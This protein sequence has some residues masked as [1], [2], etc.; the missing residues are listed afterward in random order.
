[1]A[2]VMVIGLGGTGI[3][4]LIHVKKM[5][6][7]QRKMDAEGNSQDKIKLL[8]LDTRLVPEYIQGIGGW[9]AS[10]ARRGSMGYDGMVTLETNVDYLPLGGDVYDWVQN[11]P[12]NHFMLHWL[13]KKYFCNNPSADNL[14]NIIDGA[15][16]FRQIGRLALFSELRDGLGSNIY[17]KMDRMVDAMD[18][19]FDLII[20]ASFAGGTGAA[21]F[22][23]IAHL[24]KQIAKE[25]GKN[26]KNAFGLFALPEAF[27]HT[28]NLQ[29]NESMQA[30]SFAAMRELCLRTTISDS[31]L[32][33]EMRYTEGSDNVLA[34]RTEG[35]IFTAV[36]LF[37]KRYQPSSSTSQLNPL[38]VEI[39]Y[40]VA[41][42]MASWISI[43]TDNQAQAPFVGW[44][45][46]RAE[47]IAH[48]S[49][50][51]AYPPVVGGIGT[52]SVVLPIAA[53]VESWTVRLSE[54]IIDMLLPLTENGQA[55]P[56]RRGDKD[57]IQGA[58]Q[59][60]SDWNDKSLARK[61]PAACDMGARGARYKK[62]DARV[63]EEVSNRNLSGWQDV[64]L[65]PED[66]DDDDYKKMGEVYFYH[67]SDRKFVNSEVKP[68]H[69]KERANDAKAAMEDLERDCDQRERELMAEWRSLLSG[70]VDRQ[71]TVYNKHLIELVKSELNGLNNDPEKTRKCG[72][73]GWI[74]DYVKE[75]AE[76]L[77]PGIKLL[78]DSR[79]NKQKVEGE[80]AESMILEKLSAAESNWRKQKDYIAARQQRLE[81][82]RWDLQAEMEQVLIERTQR[83]TVDMEKELKQYVLSLRTHPYG[84]INDDLIRR[85]ENIETARNAGKKMEKVRELINDP[86]WEN[87]EYQKYLTAQAALGDV[88]EQVLKDIEWE[89]EEVT[90]EAGT[91]DAHQS[92]KLN[93]RIHG[94]NLE[95]F[96][97]LNTDLI[98]PIEKDVDD[99]RVVSNTAEANTQRV[100]VRCRKI[101][102]GAWDKLN[103]VDYLTDKWPGAQTN[104]TPEAF[105]QKLLDNCTPVL[106]IPDGNKGTFLAYIMAPTQNNQSAKIWLDRALKKL[107]SGVEIDK[108]D[109]T[110]LPSE[111]KTTLQY[112]SMADI[113]DAPKLTS[114]LDGRRAYMKLSPK[115][116]GVR[117]SRAL[118]HVFRAEQR[119]AEYD[120]EDELVSTRV[121]GILEEDKR[122]ELF[123]Q[124]CAL[125]LIHEESI[126]SK[127][128]T[129]IGN[130]KKLI[131]PP[132]MDETDNVGRLIKKDFEFWLNKPEDY[133]QT[134]VPFLVAAETL[135]L[136]KIDHSENNV[137]MKNALSR[138]ND[139][140][141]DIT[142][143][144]LEIRKKIWAEDPEAMTEG[145]NA[146]QLPASEERNRRLWN[147]LYL[148]LYRRLIDN[149]N[150]Y[151]RELNS[152]EFINKIGSNS[153]FYMLKPDE[154][155]FVKL[156]NKIIQQWVDRI[157]RN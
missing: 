34:A 61:M 119:A 102:D 127:N 29:V 89:V 13:N 11:L 129:P 91:E 95:P 83:F 132:K 71:V 106:N 4:T 154:I 15:S 134:P 105:A 143:K 107:T 109:S 100:I 72:K 21:L 131:L 120:N 149:N 25:K 53:I 157:L 148:D 80:N 77:N 69:P 40:G 84:N 37:D 123:I 96:G 92:P 108:N 115:S 12:D 19:N 117:G 30:R 90:R 137:P 114:Y 54:K 24:V 87:A 36:Y 2:S 56:A 88:H 38:D 22:V 17:T 42:T 23:D 130:V 151:I 110:V 94:F 46:N 7:D 35:S 33:F 146:I 52:Y 31:D 150:D 85:R 138:L 41:P 136:R 66:E 14:L 97:I 6:I 63:L 27:A 64:L 156:M 133:S 74:L 82:K 128:N 32:G 26:A 75:Q 101:F 70:Y 140:I 60:L 124:A 73:L 47:T 44:F 142:E 147:A 58:V 20:C 144:E 104:D 121:T 50:A 79:N 5:L 39:E 9:E 28:P 43:F 152:R 99:R 145:R 126:R 118:N 155:I 45:T 139:Y 93:L 68:I 111:D 76:D 135:C 86:E 81:W 67:P 16:Q 116:I 49:Q 65:Y 8:G 78:K 51:G 122:L 48:K 153:N 18:N 10:L 141:P 55:H 113:I 103:V 98:V 1:M 3:K 59:A 57:S 62:G 112:I 125:D